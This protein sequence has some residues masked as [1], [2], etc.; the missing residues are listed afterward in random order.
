MR[1][2][3]GVAA[4]A[5]IIISATS[6]QAAT[7]A[8]EYDV[9]SATSEWSYRDVALSL[10]AMD[11]DGNSNYM[12]TEDFEGIFYIDETAPGQMTE[13]SAGNYEITGRVVADD[14]AVLGEISGFDMSFVYSDILD[15]T[16][17]FKSEGGVGP[18]GRVDSVE[19]GNETYLNM[20]TGTLTGYGALAGLDL[21]LTRM[22]ANGP[23]ATQIGAGSADALGANNHS[24]NFGL[25][26]WFF[27]DSV[28]S[29]TCMICIGNDNIT[30]MVGGDL[31][32]D[33]VS[34]VS[35]VPVPAAGL[36]ML[37]GLAGFG[38]MRRRSNRA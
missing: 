35:E 37:T 12:L 1:Y 30:N 6:V 26:N 7:L 33:L 3:G 11:A 36:L 23:Y 25:A 2:L 16:P 17:M 8:S 14:S 15:F 19:T 38:A 10:F 34:T 24:R 9:L 22:P 21:T 28:D 18:N 31:N 29:A 13:T 27:I 4:A 32:V 5:T 20:V